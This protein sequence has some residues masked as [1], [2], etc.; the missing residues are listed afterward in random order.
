MGKIQVPRRRNRARSKQI[1]S[2]R[3]GKSVIADS[4]EVLMLP[5]AS[6]ELARYITEMIKNFTEN[7][8]K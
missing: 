7:P 5:T 8:K 6:P 3:L 2:S 1:L 4:C